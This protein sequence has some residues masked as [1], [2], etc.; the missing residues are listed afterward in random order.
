MEKYRSRLKLK[1]G[2]I[3]IFVLIRI[4]NIIQY[5]TDFQDIRPAKIT[6]KPDIKVLQYLIKGQVLLD[7]SFSAN[8]FLKFNISQKVLK[9]NKLTITKI[10]R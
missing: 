3:E 10:H 9:I 7:T 6:D 2:F 4:V 5:I 8:L 1:P